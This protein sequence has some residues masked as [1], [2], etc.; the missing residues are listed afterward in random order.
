VRESLKFKIY[1]STN[2]LVDNYIILR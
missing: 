2:G 1:M